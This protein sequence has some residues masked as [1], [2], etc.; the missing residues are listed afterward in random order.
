MYRFA[1]A[2][3]LEIGYGRTVTSVDDA[4]IRK[5]DAAVEGLFLAGNPGSMLVDFFPICTYSK[6]H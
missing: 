1:A 2:V 4:H 5:V 3:M 6:Q